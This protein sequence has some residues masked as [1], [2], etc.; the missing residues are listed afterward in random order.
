MYYMNFKKIINDKIANNNRNILEK[1]NFQLHFSA[2]KNRSKFIF[3]FPRD[4]KGSF[5]NKMANHVN[6]IISNKMWMNIWL[7]AMC[8]GRENPRVVALFYSKRMICFNDI[9]IVIAP[10]CLLILCTQFN[11]NSL[12]SAPL[13]SLSHIFALNC[14]NVNKTGYILYACLKEIHN[15]TS[16][17]RNN[18]FIWIIIK[19]NPKSII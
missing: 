19:I 14:L 9:V 2:I 6:A 7:D 8:M 15:M 16:K 10:F 12:F 4:E 3:H 17:I 13:F 5:R 11:S 1:G 18:K